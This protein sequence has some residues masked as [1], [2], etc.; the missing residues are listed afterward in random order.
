M[1]CRAAWTHLEEHDDEGVATCLDAFAA[2]AVLRGE[3]DWAL[4]CL[5]AADRVRRVAGVV[6]WPFLKPLRTQ[7]EAM[8]L[9]ASGSVHDDEQAPGD[10]LTTLAAVREHFL[11]AVQPSSG[12]SG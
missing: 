8:V 1:L 11:V 4:R 6:V 2:L 10:G 12:S 3:P 5:T 9:E 7:L